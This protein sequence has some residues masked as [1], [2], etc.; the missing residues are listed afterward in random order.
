M[1]T[2][3]EIDWLNYNFPNLKV[4]EENGVIEGTVWLNSVYDKET[5]KFTAFPKP[6]IAFILC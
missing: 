1:I 4:D 6:G 2:K 5:N 3:E